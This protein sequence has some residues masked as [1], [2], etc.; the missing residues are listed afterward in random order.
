MYFYCLLFNLSLMCRIGSYLEVHLLQYVKL[1][2][3]F[4]VI[5]DQGHR[6]YYMVSSI[7]FHISYF[8]FSSWN[9]RSISIVLLSKKPPIYYKQHNEVTTKRS[10]S[11]LSIFFCFCIFC[12][13]FVF[14]ILI[15]FNII[16][17]DLIIIL[18]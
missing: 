18:D 1:N 17:L 5:Y 10:V 9:H 14:P 4:L 2:F 16:V 7:N 15:N 8:L 3:Y 6:R 13:S 11:L 12:S